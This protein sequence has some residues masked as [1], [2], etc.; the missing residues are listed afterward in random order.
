MPNSEFFFFRM[1]VTLPELTL[2]LMLRCIGEKLPSYD[3]PPDLEKARAVL[4][5]QAATETEMTEQMEIVNSRSRRPAMWKEYYRIVYYM[6]S[7][8]LGLHDARIVLNLQH[9]MRVQMRRT[10]VPNPR[11]A[12]MRYLREIFPVEKWEQT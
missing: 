6:L 5:D 11:A 8:R 1:C 12:L 10:G 4:L 2:E 7:W 3:L 9:K